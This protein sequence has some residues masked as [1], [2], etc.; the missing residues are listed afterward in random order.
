MPM[1]PQAAEPLFR[2]GQ[3]MPLRRTYSTLAK[4]FRGKQV[5]SHL[6][7][8]CPK[9]NHAFFTVCEGT[10][11]S[12]KRMLAFPYSI[13]RESRRMKEYSL[14]FRQM[15]RQWGRMKHRCKNAVSL[16]S[17]KYIHEHHMPCGARS[18]REKKTGF[19]KSKKAYKFRAP[20]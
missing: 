19:S 13:V 6:F 14:L 2:F 3:C 8:L 9:I 16:S 20:L 5:P 7:A 11:C 17:P 12:A 10:D 15:W 18:A 1:G 4:R